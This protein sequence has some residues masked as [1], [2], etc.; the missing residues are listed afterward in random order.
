MAPPDS[1]TKIIPSTTANRLK[2]AIFRTMDFKLSFEINNDQITI[3]TKRS[4]LKDLYNVFICENI[5]FEQYARIH[6][7]G[8]KIAICETASDAVFILKSCSTT[9]DNYFKTVIDEACEAFNKIM[10]EFGYTQK[11][12]IYYPAKHQTNPPQQHP[13]Y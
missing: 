12:E 8:P 13:F 11:L 6:M 7:D 1:K 5:N 10:A 4:F 9:K 2:A 3:F